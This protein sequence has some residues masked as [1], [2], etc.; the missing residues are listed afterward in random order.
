MFGVYFEGSPDME[1]FILTEWNGPPPMRKEF[2]SEAFVNQTFEWENYRP[3][4][5][6]DLEEEGG[7]ISIRPEDARR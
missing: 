3:Q 1:K 7:G 6:K 4:W 5:L 2:D